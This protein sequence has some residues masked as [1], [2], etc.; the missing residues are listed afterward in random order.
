MCK[1]RT[2]ASKKFFFIKSSI[3]VLVPREFLDGRLEVPDV[4]TFRGPSRDVAGTSRAAWD[5]SEITDVT[6]S[7]VNRLFSLSFKNG[8]DNPIRNSFHKYYMQLV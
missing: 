8:D 7:N 6:F 1:T 4:R 3:F 5:S 2:I